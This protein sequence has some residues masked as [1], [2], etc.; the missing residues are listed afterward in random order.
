MGL[1][2]KVLSC[3]HVVCLC[4][5]WAVNMRGEVGW[6]QRREVAQGVKHRLLLSCT[7]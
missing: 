7:P 6:L 4:L 5:C 2:R 1:Y 3:M